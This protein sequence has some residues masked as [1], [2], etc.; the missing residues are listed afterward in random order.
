MPCLIRKNTLTVTGEGGGWVPSIIP[1]SQITMTRWPKGKTPVKGNTFRFPLTEHDFW[2]AQV[3]FTL[4]AVVR[5]RRNA[6]LMN[7]S[8]RGPCPISVNWQF[9]LRSVPENNAASV[10]VS[11][12]WLKINSFQNPHDNK[13]SLMH[14]V[15]Y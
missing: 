11:R 12:G 15:R 6:V 8:F 9:L 7:D 10:E 3:I 2:V 13:G 5:V 14:S 1:L 4:L